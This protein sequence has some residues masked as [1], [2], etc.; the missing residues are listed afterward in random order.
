MPDYLAQR[1]NMVE[2]QVRVNDVTD[3]RVQDAMRDIP[4]ERFV[5][6]ARKATAYADAPLEVVQGRFLLE[7]RAFAKLLQLAEIKPSDNILDVGCA[8][9]YSSAIL[10]RIGGRVTAL[11]QDADLVRVASETLPS[12]GATS[13]IVVQ[14]GLAEGHKA[15]A[16][17]DVIFLNGAIEARPDSLL[18][19]LAEGGR[20]VAVVKSGASGHATVFLKEKGQV[21]SRK[22]FDADAAI[23]P[24]FREKV[25]FVF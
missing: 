13:T 7:P 14:G 25:G 11:E 9:G 2:S 21:G 5:P 18:G 10:A 23:L 17:Y 24:G 22:A 6:T 15:N 1:L 19:Q 8:T 16:P 12:V 3:I 20:L 4:R